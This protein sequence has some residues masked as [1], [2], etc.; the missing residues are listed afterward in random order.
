MTSRADIVSA[1]LHGIRDAN[2]LLAPERALEAAED[3]GLLHPPGRL[4]SLGLVNL[5]IAVENRCQTA[6]GRPV[7]LMDAVGLPPEES[8]FRDVPT[9]VAHIETTLAAEGA[10]A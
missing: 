8:P 2:A 9:L 3:A 5:L 1:V 4:D 7:S 10:N 6:L